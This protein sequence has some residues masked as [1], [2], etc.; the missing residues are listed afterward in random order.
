MDKK[1]K[2][3]RRIKIVEAL[4]N[5]TSILRLQASDDFFLASSLSG[6]VLAQ[7]NFHVMK[8]FSKT[9]DNGNIRFSFLASFFALLKL[10]GK[11]ISTLNGF[12]KGF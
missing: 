5:K 10:R 12:R 9:L 11:V 3:S 7:G 8:S 1:S 4:T 2:V 6:Y